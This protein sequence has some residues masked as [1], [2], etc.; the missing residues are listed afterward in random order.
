MA[1]DAAVKKLNINGEIEKS[2]HY[3]GPF[4]YDV[5]PSY[6]ARYIY[7][8][9]GIGVVKL[10]K[11]DMSVVSYLYTQGLANTGG[12][13]MGIKA[14][15][16]SEGEKLVVFNN[17]NIIVLDSDLKPLPHKDFGIAFVQSTEED[18]SPDIIE[19][20]FL[21]IDKNRAPVGGKVILSGGGFSKN[22]ALRV[23]LAGA[24]FDAE[25]GLDGRFSQLI[26]IP[27]L[28]KQKADFKVIGLNSGV[29]Y[30]LGFEIE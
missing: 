23:E 13:A 21:K 7:F 3:T 18:N 26:T 17:S 4:G 8:S 22:E 24:A 9:N 30:N 16:D 1:D 2:F 29:K 27:N 6:D 15:K 19:P 28:P 20:L 25:A 12:W 5:T 11:S 10:R 14:V